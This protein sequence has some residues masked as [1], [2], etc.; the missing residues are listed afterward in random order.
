MLNPRPLFVAV[1]VTLTAV[2][3]ACGTDGSSHS[4]VHEATAQQIA[5]CDRAVYGE[6]V[7]LNPAQYLR[8]LAPCN[9]LSDQQ[10]DDIVE[11]DTQDA[12]DAWTAP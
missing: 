5:A 11:T 10:W 4:A 1:A 3:A 8:S 2:A 12:I 9:H 6:L 7:Q